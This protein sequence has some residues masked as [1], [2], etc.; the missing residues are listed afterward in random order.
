MVSGLPKVAYFC[1][2]Y[3]LRSDFKIYA[4]GLGIL[5]GDI[6]KASRDMG[7]PVTGIGIKWKQGYVDQCI[8]ENGIPYDSY[9]NERYDFLE[10]T[11]VKVS[12]D[13]RDRKIWCKV[14]KTEKFDN[15]TL[16]LLDT[17]LP[18]NSDRW[19]SGQLYGWF[20]EERIAQEM[21]LGIGGIRALRALGVHTDVYHFNDSHPVFAG[22]ELI[23]EK[24]YGG[25]SFDQAYAEVR[26][27][28]VFTTHTP[29]AEG[30][31]S[32]SHRILQYMG[33]YM[34][35]NYDQ[36]N[37]I[38]GD[39]FNMTVAGLRL[40]RIANG[41]A[42]LHK[43]T[44]NRM[45]NSIDRRAPIIGITNGIHLNTWQDAR[46][47]KAYNDGEDIFVVH[48]QIKGE[49][50]KYIENRTGQILKADSL[51]IGFARRAAPYKRSDL[52]FYDEK[53]IGPYLDEGKI[54]I[55]FSGKSHPLDDG[56]KERVSKLVKMARKYPNS[57][58]FLE[59]YNMEVGAMLTRGCDIWLNNPR[60]PKEASGTS[61][62]KAAVNGVLNCSILDGWWPEVCHHGLNGWQFGNAFENENE[63]SL[64]NHD[65]QALYS[66]LLDEV[67]P[68]YYE[69]KERWAS[70]MKK[71]IETC[72]ERFS[73]ERMV[74]EYYNLM[75]EKK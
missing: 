53:L 68:L 19:V 7:Y 25:M 21:V 40:S 26:N 14:W 49:L 62:M 73:A 8:A 54:Q 43:Q 66:V 30:N 17:D 3:G 24:I 42:E 2:E 35:L 63:T 69:N 11:G 59:N 70:M 46:I 32:H 9:H 51:L 50:I 29:V 52:L 37:R 75:Y 72:A 65:A 71:S 61:G 18:E 10:D 12:V 16:Y 44:A 57:I 48:Q 13:V 36:M 60:R 58:V 55:V 4:G 28:I 67:V 15:N 47:R 64:D 6:L 22:I 33:T 56:G 20:E 31:E 23:R 1:M 27:E 34:N 74:K 39:P 45:W 38:G 5:A 41:V